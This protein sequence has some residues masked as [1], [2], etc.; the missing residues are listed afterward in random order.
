VP[1]YEYSALPGLGS[2][3]LLQVLLWNGSQ[4]VRILALVDSGASLSLI[5]ASYAEALGLDR[6]DATETTIG[7][8]GG[9]QI[10]CLRWPT[11][12]LE[13]QF[14]D[15]RFPFGGAFVEFPPT[16]DALNLLG[17]SDF[18]QR[19]M[20]QFWDAAEMLNIDLSPDYPRATS[21]PASEGS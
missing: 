4:R 17:R 7:T 8:A 10:T 12:Q 14:G 2:A 16:A 11:A 19:Y 3:P 9:G 13:L 1:W 18:F 20:I 5:D 21:Q 15:D 6:A